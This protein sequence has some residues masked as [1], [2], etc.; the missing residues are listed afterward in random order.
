MTAANARVADSVGGGSDSLVKLDGGAGGAG[1]LNSGGAMKVDGTGANTTNG[2]LMVDGGGVGEHVAGGLM[3]GARGARVAYAACV[4]AMLFALAGCS[5][6]EGSLLDDLDIPMLG[7]GDEKRS[8]KTEELQ[9]PPDLDGI[10]SQ[11]AFRMPDRAVSAKR[12][13]NTYVLPQNL[14]MRIVREG[15]IAWLEVNA[16]PVTVW[17]EIED[18]W[19]DRGF[20]LVE[21]NPRLGYALTNWRRRS[22]ADFGGGVEDRFITRLSREPR[23]RTNVYIVN[24]QVRRQDAT[25]SDT[26]AEI[27]MLQALQDRL[28]SAKWALNAQVKGVVSRPVAL[29]IRNVDGVPVLSIGDGFSRVWRRMTVVLQRVGFVVRDSDRSRGILTFTPEVRGA[30][31][32]SL[33]RPPLLQFR[34]LARDKRTLITAHVYG[35]RRRLNY[36]E[37]RAVLSQVLNGYYIDDNHIL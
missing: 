13:G 4:A 26:D 11:D 22:A 28:A 34:L 30:Q 5:T 36:D 33:G 19:R 35:D 32:E 14:N 18:F 21:S 29:N 7:D 16:D 24:R 3:T 25:R 1:K 23:G 17:P 2:N 10:E 12:K 31:R 15:G 37:A 20:R 6:G 27:A 9:L 8:G